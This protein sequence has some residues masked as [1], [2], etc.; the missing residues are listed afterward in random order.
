MSVCMCVHVRKQRIMRG[1]LI[2]CIESDRGKRVVTLKKGQ[3]VAFWVWLL[4]KPFLSRLS[5]GVMVRSE[6]NSEQER[7]NMS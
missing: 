1:K 4:R 2:L 6:M 3:A 5:F 7:G